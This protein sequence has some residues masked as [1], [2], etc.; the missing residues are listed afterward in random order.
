MPTRFCDKVRIAPKSTNI[1]LVVSWASIYDRRAIRMV[2]TW[3]AVFQPCITWHTGT[4]YEPVLIHVVTGLTDATQRSIWFPGAKSD[5]IKSLMCLDRSFS[6]GMDQDPGV[7]LMQVLLRGIWW[8][9]SSETFTL[10]LLSDGW[11]PRTVVDAGW[12]SQGLKDWITKHCRKG[13]PILE[14]LGTPFYGYTESLKRSCA[15]A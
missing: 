12:Q 8:C 3:I 13:R 5:F 4:G 7:E 2:R 6:P 10:L 11:S 1:S 15:T 14:S 9:T